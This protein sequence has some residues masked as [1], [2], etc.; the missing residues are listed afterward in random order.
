[1]NK[2]KVLYIHHGHGIGGASVSL[3]DLIKNLDGN[4]V[5]PVFLLIHHKKNKELSKILSEHGEVIFSSG[6]KE[7]SHT[8]G[9][10]YNF[11]TPK[12]IIKFFI[13]SIFFIPS[14]LFTYLYIKKIKPDIIHLNSFSLI[15]SLIGAKLARI[16]VI[17]HIR[18]HIADG[19]FGIRKKLFIS[20]VT[21]FSDKIISICKTNAEPFLQNQDI[22]S[23][24][25]VVLYEPI[26][27]KRFRPLTKKEK[28]MFR[29]KYGFDLHSKIVLFLGGVNPIK[30][31]YEF[32]NAAQKILEDKDINENVVFVVCGMDIPLKRA[33]YRIFSR[34][35]YKYKVWN[36][37]TTSRLLQEN[38]II[39][40]TIKHI[41]ELIGI[42]DVIVFP[43][44]TPHFARPLVE[45][46]FMKAC[47]VGSNFPEIRE[48]IFN[49]TFGYLV[50][51]KNITQ[52]SDVIKN[53]IK[54]SC[55]FDLNA[56]ITLK[57]MFDVKRHNRLLL[58]I[59]FE[60]T[61]GCDL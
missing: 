22:H 35:N 19:Y 3:I 59:Y 29:Q 54:K 55:N 18:E 37:L 47:V 33:I 13:N 16:P 4:V 34:F 23:N 15:P 60:L 14:I 26:D 7:Y 48:I 45:G 61:T 1:M 11:H 50:E 6:I 30:G 9:E 20:I 8:T 21:K 27:A 41:E 31:T 49:R 5:E 25:I 38:V 52:L 12:S 2:I 53:S 58:N 32:L 46:L 56:Y 44:T 36:L 28:L 39:F 40:P 17:I 10:W 51:P 24:K 43:S 57:K 42:S